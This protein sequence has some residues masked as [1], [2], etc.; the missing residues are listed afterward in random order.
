MD[1]EDDKHIVIC[2]ALRWFGN[3][4]PLEIF[5]CN[6]LSESWLYLSIYLSIMTFSGYSKTHSYGLL[7][8]YMLD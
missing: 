1:Q 7:A 4:A 8:N 6:I 3:E 2:G 5:G